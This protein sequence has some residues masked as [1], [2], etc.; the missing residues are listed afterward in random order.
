MNYSALALFFF[1]L[2]GLVHAD[3]LEFDFSGCS[4]SDDLLNTLTNLPGCIVETFFAFIVSGLIAAIQ[5]FIEASFQFLFSSPNPMLFCEPY[6]AILVVLES[7]FSIVLMGLA[8]MFIMRSNDVEGRLAAKKWLENL[9]VMIIFLSFSFH[10]FQVML[11]FN[12]YLSTSFASESM[13]DIFTPSASFTSAIFALLMLFLIAI[14]LV[15]T[16]ITLL[17][18]YILIP[19]LL[20]LFPIAIFLYFIPLTQSWGKTFLKMIA[21]I[22]FMTSLDALILLGLAALFN[23]ADPNLASPLVKAFAILF[24]FGALGFINVL[25]FL[26]AFMSV[27][28]KSK[29][30]TGVIGFAIFS[31]VL[32]R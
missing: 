18:R 21:I 12:T 3:G 2:S 10:L 11:D 9:C 6:N 4:G 24:G 27:A 8:L 32:K 16:Y 15:L 17:L 5:G 25:L 28:T 22:V 13:I 14:Q 31:K 7:L 23:T 29:V 30:L 26:K 19:F 20:L 1:F